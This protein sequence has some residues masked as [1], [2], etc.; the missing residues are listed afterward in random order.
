MGSDRC[1]GTVCEDF[2]I[3]ELARI[4]ELVGSAGQRA[5]FRPARTDKLVAAVHEVAANAVLYAGKGRATIAQSPDGVYV[6]ID[7]SG[8]GLPADLPRGLPA[9]NALGGRGLWLARHLCRQLVVSSSPSGVNV[10]LFVP[11][12]NVRT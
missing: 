5:G 12:G 7:D 3:H 11:V 6:E 2:T 8:P 1:Y 4:R 9:P 10:R